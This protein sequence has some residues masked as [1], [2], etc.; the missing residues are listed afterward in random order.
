MLSSNKRR[1]F[2]HLLYCFYFPP[3][4]QNDIALVL[5]TCFTDCNFVINMYDD[6]MPVWNR[7]VEIQ[8][9]F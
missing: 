2:I 3:F 1:C 9:E 4:F 8:Y 7:G 6:F 5:E